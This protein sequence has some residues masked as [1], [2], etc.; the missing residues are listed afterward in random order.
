MKVSFDTRRYDPEEAFRRAVERYKSDNKVKGT[1]LVRPVDVHYC[2]TR[3]K[4]NRCFRW[5]FDVEET[6]KGDR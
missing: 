6:G 2:R 3:E 4:K 1:L 5:E